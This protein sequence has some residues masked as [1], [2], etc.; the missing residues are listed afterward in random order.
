MRNIKFI[1]ISVIPLLL[2][3]NKQK[4]KRIP[5]IVFSDLYFPAQDVGDNF[6]IIIPYALLELELK[7]VIFDITEKYRREG[8]VPTVTRE[9]GFIPIIQLNYIFNKNVP[10]ACSPFVAM[11]TVDDKM[12]NVL[13]FQQEGINLF[14][15]LLENSKQKVEVVCTGSGRGLAVAFNR[16]P[17]LMKEKIKTI[18]FCAGASSET[19]RE[20]NI[21]LDTLAAY[22]L[23]TSDLPINIYPCATDKGPFDKGQNNTFW[24]MDNLNFISNMDVK[25]QKYLQFS[26]LQKNRTD[27]LNYIETYVKKEDRESMDVYEIG[28]LYGSG[29]KHYVWETAVWQQ[30]TGR[31]IVKL[32]NGKIR[33]I[34]VDKVTLNDIV[35][36][37]MIRPCKLNVQKSGLFSFE[38]T[39]EKTNFGIYFREDPIQ[40]EQW[41]RE[42]LA[43]LFISFTINN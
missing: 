27:F 39:E 23:L 42:A 7:G 6:D 35:F 16:N 29:G 5:V 24:A 17:K 8:N 40:N 33:L 34:P 28:K 41:L 1:I 36:N 30:I 43:E 38:Y 12:E 3:C 4:E 14:F 15:E 26:F 9:P 10:A 20:W 19:F 37:E 18:H 13:A 22:R 21:E 25:L 11:R 31:K 32:Q 2:A